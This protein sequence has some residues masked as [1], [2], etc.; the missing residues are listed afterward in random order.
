MHRFLRRRLFTPVLL[1]TTLLGGAA[2]LHAQT[3][4]CDWC[5][6]FSAD[7]YHDCMDQGLDGCGM[8]YFDMMNICY[9]GGCGY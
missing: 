4:G 9:D 6:T 5:F 1:L 8:L 3:P 2:Y 7:T